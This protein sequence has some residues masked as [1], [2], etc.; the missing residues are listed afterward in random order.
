[1][2]STRLLDDALASPLPRPFIHRLQHCNF[3][4][5]CSYTQEQY[6]QDTPSFACTQSLVHQ[7]YACRT[8]GPEW[9]VSTIQASSAAL[10]TNHQANLVP[11]AQPGYSKLSCSRLLVAC[12]LAASKVV[13]GHLAQSTCCLWPGLVHQL[14][15]HGLGVSQQLGGARR[16][17]EHTSL[18][19]Q[20]LV[21]LDHGVQAVGNSDDGARLKHTLDH[22]LHL[23]L[24]VGVHGGGGLVQAQHGHL[25]QVGARQAHQLLLAQ[26]PGARARANHPALQATS[27][28]DLA[29]QISFLDGLPQLGVG[30]LA[31]GVQVGAHGAGEHHGLLGDD[32]QAAAQAA[33]GHGRDVDAVHVD[34]ALV[35][36]KHAVQRQQ[37]GGLAGAGAAHDADLVGV[38]ELVGDALERKGGGGGVAH[39]H[40]VEHDGALLGPVDGGAIS[41][42][43]HVLV[44]LGGNHHL[45]VGGVATAQVVVRVGGVLGLGVVG[46]LALHSH[47]LSQPANLLNGGHGE[48]G[49]SQ[50]AHGPGVE[51]EH[52]DGVGEGQAHGGS[53][54]VVSHAD[55]EA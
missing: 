24:G 44:L 39:P 6:D 31:E 54:Q 18:H 38:V 10:Y 25:A 16:L 41:I 32:G 35:Q 26:G 1:M 3:F 15:E 33:Q 27:C 45:H 9:A 36:L 30:V 51:H 46:G 34:A 20:H 53:A 47:V 29:L 22:G 42:Q 2:V 11:R 21:G 4:R 37:H 8:H 23:L 28:L 50:E 7:L 5:V 52:L 14:G 48:Q 40:V 43:L 49:L 55:S 12:S 13:G 19:H 17:L